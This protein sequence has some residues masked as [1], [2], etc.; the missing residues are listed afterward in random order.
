MPPKRSPSPTSPTSS[1]KNAPKAG[2]SSSW[3]PIRTP[4]PPPHASQSRL[5]TPAPSPPPLTALAPASARWT[6]SF[7]SSAG[8]NP[9]PEF[10]AA[11]APVRPFRSALRACQRHDAVPTPPPVARRPVSDARSS[12]PDPRPRRSSW[13]RAP[14]INTPTFQRSP[15]VP[16][17]LGS[18][19]ITRPAQ[20]K[21]PPIQCRVSLVLSPPA[22]RSKARPHSWKISA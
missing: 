20:R 11:G 8:S 6:N 16:W 2:N 19:P 9:P 3:P 21:A 5:T 18:D 7:A 17:L 15:P 1:P 13:E 10:A 4:S 22:D 12:P 14:R